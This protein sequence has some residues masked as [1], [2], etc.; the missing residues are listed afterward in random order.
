MNSLSRAF[1]RFQG[2][3]QSLTGL[4]VT[5][6]DFVYTMAATPSSAASLANEDVDWNT[7]L[8]VFEKLLVIKALSEE[9][10]T[11]AYNLNSDQ[12]TT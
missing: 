2:L 10:V 3:A 8:T 12:N 1:P 9:K 6:G 7:R 5:V 4:R 11:C